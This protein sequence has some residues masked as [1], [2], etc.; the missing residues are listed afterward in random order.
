MKYE[1]KNA[2]TKFRK[3]AAI[4]IEELDDRMKCRELNTEL[5]MIGGYV[6]Y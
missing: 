6:G 1:Y 3:C 5:A 2:K 4:S